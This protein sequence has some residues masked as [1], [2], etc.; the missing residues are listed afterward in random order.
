MADTRM[1]K[2]AAVLVNYSIGVKKGDW[3]RI[4]GPSLA[5]DLILA[6]YVEALKAG[7]NPFFSV[8]LPGFTYAYFRHGSDEQLKFISPTLRLETDKLDGLLAIWGNSNTKE[9]IFG[10]GALV[11]FLS[12]AITLEP[13]DIVSTG[14]PAGVGFSYKPPKWLKPGDDVVVEIEGIGQ[15][16]NP[17]VAEE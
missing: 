15:L 3:L 11:E 7:A 6:A 13:G 16:R 9:L 5:Q 17:V 4:E 1:Q 12:S 2:L 14:T 8:M 10:I